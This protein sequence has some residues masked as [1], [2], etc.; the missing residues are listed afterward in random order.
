MLTHYVETTLFCYQAETVHFL[1][2]N[3]VVFSYVS[4]SDQCSLSPLNNNRLSKVLLM[5]LLQNYN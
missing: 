4:V 3:E 1:K 5:K 2:R